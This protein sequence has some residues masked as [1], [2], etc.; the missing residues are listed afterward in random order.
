[1]G[2][3]STAGP[4]PRTVRQAIQW[5]LRLRNNVANPNLRRQCEAWRA[6]SV[7]HELAWQRV[8]SLDEELS[9]NLRSVP[10]GQLALQTLDI[11]TARLHR[12]QALKLLGG[13]AFVGTAAWLGRGYTPW[14]QWTS[15][16]ATTVGEQRSFRLPDGSV[17]RLNT[18]SAADIQFN[19]QRRRVNLKQGELMLNCAADPAHRSFWLSSRDGLLEA[20]DARLVACQE[21]GFT[22]LSVLQGRVAIH[23]AQG[24]V[25]W[26]AP[27][28]SFR[29]TAQE[30]SR[31]PTPAMEPGAWADGLIVTQG[32][33][34]REFLAQVSRY[35]HGLLG[36]SDAVAELRLSGVFRLQQ[37]EQLIE[38]LP[39]LLPVRIRSRT[40]WWISLE[41]LA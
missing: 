13:A 41:A 2:V 21:A 1:M 31:L 32:T 23:P 34:L 25:V 11:G 37:P 40:R 10:G 20:F 14:E 39:Q 22:R 35:R 24:T 26:A 27:G 15:D 33:P 12:R 16:F 19:G 17:L 6:A 28:E 5:L 3:E 29:I 7:Q 18:R 36:C 38:L 8:Q 4:D 30:V 9:A